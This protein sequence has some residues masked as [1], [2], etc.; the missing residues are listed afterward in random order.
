VDLGQSVPTETLVQYLSVEFLVHAWDI[1][2]GTGASLDASEELIMA[3]GDHARLTRESI[4][5]Q[6]DAYAEAQPVDPG[7][8]ALD[9][10]LALTGR[11]TVQGGA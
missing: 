11:S 2:S 4:F 7:A 6:A 8:S 5:F 10:L 9:Q 3:V 1:S